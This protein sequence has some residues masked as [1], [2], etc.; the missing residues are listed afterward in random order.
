[1]PQH[2]PLGLSFKFISGLKFSRLLGAL[3]MSITFFFRFPSWAAFSQ[4]VL[5]WETVFAMRDFLLVMQPAL[6]VTSTRTSING[7]VLAFCP[8]CV[9]RLEQWKWCL[10]AVCSALGSDRCLCM[11][12]HLL[13]SGQSW[14]GEIV[15]CRVAGVGFTI[16][17]LTPSL[18]LHS[19]W[20]WP[21]PFR[22][23]STCRASPSVPSMPSMR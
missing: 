14:L 15:Q 3:F 19:P 8:K 7:A 9:A 16:P 20:W 10:Q 18:N 2:C 22:V 4:L 12:Y 13:S 1:M 17:S 23:P 5:F 11:C 21:C 6:L